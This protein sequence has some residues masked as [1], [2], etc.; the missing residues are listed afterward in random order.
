METIKLTDGDAAFLLG[1]GGKTKHKIAKVSGADLEL[2]E[3][4]LTLEI[5][6]SEKTR[7]AARKSGA[8]RTSCPGLRTFLWAL[9][10]RYIDPA[11]NELM[12]VFT[13]KQKS[14][15]DM[16]SKLFYIILFLLGE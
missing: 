11:E 7:R 3:R 10:I 6:G 4:D 8:G 2:F 1:K 13:Q 16:M 14:I 12:K 9:H 5:R 15:T